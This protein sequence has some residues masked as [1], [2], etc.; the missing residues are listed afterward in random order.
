MLVENHIWKQDGMAMSSSSI[1]RQQ[2]VGGCRMS[3][4]EAPAEAGLGIAAD[5]QLLR[6]L[7]S[8]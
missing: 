3:A 1:S 4:R 7:G 8:S 6:S 5:N 2:I